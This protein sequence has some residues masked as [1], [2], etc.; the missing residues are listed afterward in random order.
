MLSLSANA[1]INLFL[2]ITGKRSDGYHTVET[3]MQEI[4]LADGISLRL[5]PKS[6]GIKLKANITS[7]PLDERNIAYKAASKYI[8]LSGVDCGVE[9]TLNK[10][11]PHEAG[12]GGGSTDGA[13]VLMGLNELC[14]G[15]IDKIQMHNLAASLGADVPFFLYGG[16]ALMSGI[17]TD[18]I[19]SV[20]SPDLH[21]V[22]SKP[23]N[24]ISTPAAYRYLDEVH[25]DFTEH[26]KAD[27]SPLLEAI[28]D[29]SADKISTEIY[30]VFESASDVLCPD[31]KELRS[32]LSDNSYGAMLCGSG[33]SVFAITDGA[34][35]SARLIDKLSEKFPNYYATYAT[36]VKKF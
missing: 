12:M 36:T 17:G 29:N 2:E 10:E 25:N 19:R 26:S 30:N 35:H 32:F 14:S 5:L 6:E 16:T 22:I 24:G 27:V 3:V 31:T 21:L 23:M 11:I 13:A 9:I 18:Y 1:K 8:A 33:S 28:S 7:I 15:A 4:S 34:V 20:R